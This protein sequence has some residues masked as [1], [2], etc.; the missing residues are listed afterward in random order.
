MRVTYK[1]SENDLLEAQGKH[2]GV[3]TKAIRVWGL[4]L[5]LAGLVSIA[6][7]AKQY[8]NVILP[9]L[10]GLFFL[11][12]LRL[13]VRRSFRQDNRLQQPF[14]AAISQDGIDVSSPTGSSKY[15]WSAFTRYLES[16]NLFLVYQAPKVFNV[17]PKRAF[18]PGEEESFRNLLSERLGTAS[19]AHRKRISPQTWI[20]LAVVAISGILLVMALHNI[21]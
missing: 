11:F 14:E 20:F 10:L 12:G 5:I 15:A 16:K 6:S 2:G 17:F 8:A 13:L 7:N 21:R 1:L 3:W 9:I 4:L 19:V 18:A